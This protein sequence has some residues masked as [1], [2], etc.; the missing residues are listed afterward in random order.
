[1]WKDVSPVAKLPVI[2]QME[3]NASLPLNLTLDLECV[4]QGGKQRIWHRSCSAAAELEQSE[5]KLWE[6]D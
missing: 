2:A 3:W 4:E 6:R 5:P 1:M